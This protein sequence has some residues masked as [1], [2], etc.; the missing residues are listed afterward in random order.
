[1]YYFLALIPQLQVTTKRNI[2]KSSNGYFFKTNT[3]SGSVPILFR[4]KKRKNVLSISF[5]F[6]TFQD[7]SQSVATSQF[8]PLNALVALIETSQLIC[9][10]SQL[11]GFYM[12][13]TLAFKGLISKVC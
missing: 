3:L 8:N 5:S 12:R 9:T 4:K 11:T 2:K 7:T 6:T 13:A 1:M 10:A